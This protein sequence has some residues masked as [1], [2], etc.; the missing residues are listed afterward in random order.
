MIVESFSGTRGIFNKELVELSKRYAFVYGNK[1]K[2][3]TVVIGTDTR[4]GCDEIKQAMIQALPLCKII[5]LGIAPTP[6]IEFAVRYFKA[7]GGI[8]ITGSHNEPEWNG[9]KLLQNSGAVLKAKDIAEVISE[10]KGVKEVE[11]TKKEVVDKHK[12]AIDAYIDF[13]LD[14]VGDVKKFK[15]ILD[16][17]GGTALLMKELFEKAGVE[18]IFINDKPGEFKRKVEPNAESLAYL[19]D[20]VKKEKADFAAGFDCDADR[21]E[22]VT[23]KGVVSG[24]LVLAM[25]VDYILSKKKGTVVTNDATSGVVEKIAEKHGCK[26]KEVEVGEISVVSEMERL[27]SPVGGEGSSSGAI[28]AP[29]KCRDGFLNILFILSLMSK[30]NKS[31]Q[32]IIDSYPRFYT[33]ITKIRCDPDKQTILRK[34]LIN[35]FSK[36]NK[37]QL[38]GD[39]TGGLKIL[40]D[41]SYLWFRASKTEPGVFRIYADSPD[42][43]EA[44]ELLKKGEEVFER[45]LF[46]LTRKREVSEP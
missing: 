44:D 7:D 42:E 11:L 1:I 26:I 8:I 27:N 4:K 31:L 45:S 30:R 17:N 13:A 6:V 23:E 18:A 20:M 10:V 22:L 34:K 37:I 2:P 24:Q 46:F 16:S 39:E 33:K 25:V 29:T 21:V 40:F 28:V 41:G 38:T 35:Y 3:K 43:K 36:D 15:I 19:K 14:L 9:W 12:E 5:D 32:E